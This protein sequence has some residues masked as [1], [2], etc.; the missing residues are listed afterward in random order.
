MNTSSP[1]F[2]TLWRDP[3][4][5]LGVITVVIPTI[6][7][8]FPNIYLY[9]VHGAA[10]SFEEAMR[11]WGMI[12]LIFGAFYLVEP[13]SYYPILGLSGTYISFL[14]GNISNL[15]IPCSAVAQEVAGT[16]SGTLE[17]EIVST[18]GIT[19]SVVTNLLFLSLAVVAG[20]VLLGLFPPA[21]QDAFRIYTV[22]AIFGAM[23]GQFALKAP[24][25]LIPAV[26][27]PVFLLAIVPTLGLPEI[28]SLWF[29]E[30][31]SM[32]WFVIASSVFGTVACA[33]VFYKRGILK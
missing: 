31:F 1:E 27:I 24:I 21:L 29:P 23:L 22:P 4:V 14:S 11:A 8:F 19:G 30:I 12:I 20:P 16:E 26:G 2:K 32:L 25:L 6:M 5:R 28:P 18:L 13:I 33:R 15:R 9:L 3:V 10:P 7:C 17:A